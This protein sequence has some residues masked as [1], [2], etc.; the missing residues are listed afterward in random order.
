MHPRQGGKNTEFSYV[1]I[2]TFST[3]L[4]VRNV[5]VSKNSLNSFSEYDI[6]HYLNYTA[7]LQLT[8]FI[9]DHLS[10]DVD[11]QNYVKSIR[12]FNE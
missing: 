8:E 12:K 11:G 5:Y 6:S 4:R 1:I 2:N 9:L 7:R 10:F 3:F